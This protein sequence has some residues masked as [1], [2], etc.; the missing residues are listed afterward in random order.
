MPL[1]FC[2]GS[3]IARMAG[4]YDASVVLCYGSFI[5]RMAGSYG[6]SVAFV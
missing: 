6:A 1:W 2:Y 4:S 3:F 5:A